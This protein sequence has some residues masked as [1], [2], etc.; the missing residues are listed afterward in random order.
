MKEQYHFISGFG[1]IRIEIEAEYLGNFNQLTC[2]VENFHEE[3]QKMCEDHS[4][5]FMA[6]PECP[7]EVKPV[8]M[9]SKKWQKHMRDY[10]EAHLCQNCVHECCPYN[11]E[12]NNLPF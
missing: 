9:P 6:V 12:N 5:A 3:F 7:K 4:V 8:D 1:T 11:D 2:A 10:R